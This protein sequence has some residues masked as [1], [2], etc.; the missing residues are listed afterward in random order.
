MAEVHAD[1]RRLLREHE[2]VSGRKLLSVSTLDQWTLFGGRWRLIEISE[3]QATVEMCACTGE[4]MERLQ[5]D[6]PGTIGFL[7][8]ADLGSAERQ[9]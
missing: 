6:D 7:R 1:Q 2:G 8:N 4:A 5:T 9:E 3:K